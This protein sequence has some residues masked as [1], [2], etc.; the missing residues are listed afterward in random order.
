MDAHPAAPLDPSSEGVLKVA[1]QLACVAIAAVAAWSSAFV[2]VGNV[3]VSWLL[4]VCER[5]LDGARLH[6]DV[7]EINPPLSIWLYM[8]FAVAERATGLRAELWLAVGVPVFAFLSTWLFGRI[9][10][11]G[12]L[13]VRPWLMP[14]ALA[15]LLWLFP[16]DF[17]QREQFA[18]IALLPW[19]ALLA[20]RDRNADFV[21]GTPLQRIM[22]GLGAALFVSLKPPMAVFALVLPALYLCVVR[23]SARPL[24]T[25]ETLL[26]AA[27]TL[28]YIAWVVLFHRA[29]VTE[30]MPLVRHLYLPS[31]MSV[32]AMLALWPVVTVAAIAAAVFI[33]TRPRGIDRLAM[34]MLLAGAGYLPAFLLMGKGWSYQA[35]PTLTF[36]IL[37]LLVQLSRL[38]AE[39]P[40]T[41]LAR[42]G[43]SAG[44][45]MVAQLFASE[46]LALRRVANP[47]A[48]A[49]AIEAVVRRPTMASIATRLQPAHPLTRMVG[50][51]YVSAYPAFWWADNAASLGAGAD[52]ARSV[53]IEEMRDRL[54]TDSAR[55]LAATR[56]DII[57]DG[58]TRPTPGQRN[59]LDNPSI[60]RVLQSYRVLY[61]DTDVTVWLRSDIASPSPGD[62][63]AR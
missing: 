38:S 2:L 31:R 24:F 58:G 60:E 13:A 16:R 63:S 42:I 61:R 9:L 45:L 20:A 53:R 52:V 44:L 17:G 39:V 10:H 12:G 50:G 1:A 14:A 27:M 8:P 25:T 30:I 11:Q 28:F 23:R 15:T 46:L 35:L 26:G 54:I 48:P 56:P 47:A 18:T 21:A 19:L 36:V 41:L 33:T 43:A 3:D 49:A 32:A 57:I 29:Y 7:I 40:P 22:A 37:A 6:L 51:R 4:I 62:A 5:L 59:V 55:D 34:L